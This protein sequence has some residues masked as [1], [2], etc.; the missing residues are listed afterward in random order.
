MACKSFLL[1]EEADISV[2]LHLSFFQATQNFFNLFWIFHVC[3]I[4]D[5]G[6]KAECEPAGLLPY[7]V[8]VVGNSLPLLS[9]GH[10]VSVTFYKAV[11]TK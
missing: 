8:C 5:L 6:P 1:V 10:L 2:C 11:K 3:F 4:S 9:K 7:L